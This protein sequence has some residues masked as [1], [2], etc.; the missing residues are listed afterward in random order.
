MAKLFLFY[1][2]L[3]WVYLLQNS[4]AESY[5]AEREEWQII[6]VKYISCWRPVFISIVDCVYIDEKKIT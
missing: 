3:L 1:N 5:V 2:R 6:A 4:G